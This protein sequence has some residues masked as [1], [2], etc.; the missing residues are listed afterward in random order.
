MSRQWGG[1]IKKSYLDFSICFIAAMVT[2]PDIIHKGIFFFVAL[3]MLSEFSAATRL[4][5]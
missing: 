1:V 3:C 4:V 5:H 2:N